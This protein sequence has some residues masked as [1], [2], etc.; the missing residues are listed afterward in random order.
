MIDRLIVG[1]GN[2]GREYSRTRHNLGSNVVEAL[3]QDDRAPLC[4]EAKFESKMARVHIE[5]HEVALVFPATYMNESGRAVGAICA[6]YKIDRTALIVICDDMD[7]PFGHIRIRARGSSG[8]HKGLVSIEQA[9]GTRE[10]TRVRLGIGR[11]DSEARD[12]V[13][14]TFTKEERQALPEFIERAKECCR[15]LVGEDVHHV[16]CDVN[17]KVKGEEKNEKPNTQAI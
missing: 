8:G 10:Y 11:G 14:S 7:L 12:Y 9:L 1:L 3:A 15:R 5:G 6:F 13:L 4:L 17:K 16:A 2:P